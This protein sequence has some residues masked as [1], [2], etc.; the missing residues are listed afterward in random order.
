MKKD[1][2]NGEYKRVLLISE[3][4]ILNC[5]NKLPNLLQRNG[6]EKIFSFGQILTE[7][8]IRQ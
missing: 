4:G 3:F 7:I 2:R 6:R 5:V 8:L 1:R